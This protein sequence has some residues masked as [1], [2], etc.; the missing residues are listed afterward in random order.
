MYDGISDLKRSWP[1]VSHNCNLTVLS[2][3]Y[4][5]FDKKSIPIVACVHQKKETRHHNAIYSI[6]FQENQSIAI[7]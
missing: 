3:K 6:D 2:S 4:M 5:V 1:A 7:I